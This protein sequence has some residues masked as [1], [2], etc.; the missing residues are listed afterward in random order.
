MIAREIGHRFAHPPHLAAHE[1]LALDGCTSI[2][3]IGEVVVRAFHRYRVRD[4]RFDRAAAA[5]RPAAVLDPAAELLL[6]RV[7]D[8]LA[9]RERVALRSC[10]QFERCLA[11]AILEVLA[12]QP[13]TVNPQQPRAARGRDPRDL[14]GGILAKLGKC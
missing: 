4:R 1:H 14:L 12:A 3:Q 6:E 13:P 9:T 7:Q 8:V 5:D 10:E 11:V 2:L